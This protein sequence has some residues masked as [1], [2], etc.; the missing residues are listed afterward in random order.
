MRYECP[1]GCGCTEPPEENDDPR[2]NERNPVRC[3]SCGALGEMAD[4]SREAAETQYPVDYFAGTEW[5]S[6]GRS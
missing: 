4:F 3:G 1:D 5:M 6:H 2:T